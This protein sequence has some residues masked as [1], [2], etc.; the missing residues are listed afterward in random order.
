MR[1]SVGFR[2]VFARLRYRIWKYRR[3]IYMHRHKLFGAN[4]GTS[5][6]EAKESM[7]PTPRALENANRRKQTEQIG[8]RAAKRGLYRQTEQFT[9]TSGVCHA[10]QMASRSPFQ[11]SALPLLLLSLNGYTPRACKPPGLFSGIYLVGR[12]KA[13]EA[14]R[15]SIDKRRPLSPARALGLNEL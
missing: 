8:Y 3:C 2:L 9:L 1:E 5:G 10:K 7:T 13:L 12:N 4:P 14:G 15:S 11:Q 6:W